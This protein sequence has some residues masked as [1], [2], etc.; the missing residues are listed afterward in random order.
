[1]DGLG[2]EDVGV[3]MY[4]MAIWYILRPFGIYYGD[5]V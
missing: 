4:I 1:M 2:M 5:L 3:Y